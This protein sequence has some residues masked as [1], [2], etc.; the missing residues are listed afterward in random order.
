[1]TNQNNDKKLKF[2]EQESKDNVIDIIIWGGIT[3]V[4]L[5]SIAFLAMNPQL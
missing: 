2:L 3:T 1:M 5:G 4:L